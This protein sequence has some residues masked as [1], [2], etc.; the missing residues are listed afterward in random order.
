MIQKT[1]QPNKTNIEASVNKIKI[2]LKP[3]Q[4]NVYFS[5]LGE[6]FAIKIVGLQNLFQNRH[7]LFVIGK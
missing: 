6:V 3:Q 5:S 4:Y 7:T 1:R 2:S